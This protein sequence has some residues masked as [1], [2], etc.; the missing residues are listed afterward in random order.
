M[1][2]LNFHGL[3]CTFETLTL[4]FLQLCKALVSAGSL[5]CLSHFSETRQLLWHTINNDTWYS[6]SNLVLPFVQAF[7]VAQVGVEIQAVPEVE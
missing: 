1:T 6:L 3:A 5:F 2:P 7:Y 4:T